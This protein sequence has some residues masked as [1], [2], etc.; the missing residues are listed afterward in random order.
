MQEKTRC[1]LKG[2]LPIEDVCRKSEDWGGQ[3]GGGG[4][5]EKRR[6]TGLYVQMAASVER[7][8]ESCAG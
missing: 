7:K 2:G 6:K 8:K 3:R 4:H 5:H 1:G